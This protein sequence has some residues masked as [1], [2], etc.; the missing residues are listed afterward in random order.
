[1]GRGAVVMSKKE[2]GERTGVLSL[3]IKPELR[4][5]LDA[6]C[7]RGIAG[8]SLSITVVAERGLELALAE[9]EAKAKQP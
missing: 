3:R 9:I 4:K 8:Y 7:A 1:M 6:A 2:R 5:R